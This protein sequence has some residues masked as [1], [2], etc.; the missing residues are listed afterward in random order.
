MLLA[1]IAA[2]GAAWT[3]LLSMVDDDDDGPAIESVAFQEDYQLRPSSEKI[4][5]IPQSTLHLCFVSI[6]KVTVPVSAIQPPFT[7]STRD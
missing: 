1:V 5:Q 6:G 7:I 3:I 2:N 4:Q